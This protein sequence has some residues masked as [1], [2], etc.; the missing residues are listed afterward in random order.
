MNEQP[1]L[2]R[3][4]SNPEI[5]GRKPVIRGM[6]IFIE[7]VLSLMAHRAKAWRS[8]WRIIPI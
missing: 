5:F 3:I 2:K 8:F 4:T 6:R 1:L 7:L